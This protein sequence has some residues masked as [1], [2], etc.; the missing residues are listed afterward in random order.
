[1]ILAVED[2]ISEAVL[3][4]LIRVFRPELN[5]VNSIGRR[6]K[7]YLI[8]KAHDLNRTARSITIFLMM[9]LDRRSPCPADL[10]RRWLGSAQQSNLLFRLAVMEVES[11]ILADRENF[12]R[13]LGVAVHR[14]PP[15]TDAIDDPKELVVNLA[16]RSSIRHIRDE[17][18][19]A[20]G[21][22]AKVGPAYNPRICQFV[23]SYWDPKAACSSSRSLQRAVHRLESA[24]LNRQSIS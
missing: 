22:I 10:L 16:R 17:L 8:N 6:G 4:E 18:V 15:D 12:S 7:N 21:S 20:R 9:D 14:L 3:R 2:E 23:S 5:V 1:M 13:F 24:F 11:W 19:P